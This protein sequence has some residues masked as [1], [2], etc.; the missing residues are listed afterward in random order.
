MRNY[1]YIKCVNTAMNDSMLKHTCQNCQKPM[2]GR[3]D[4]KFCDSQCK[5]EYHNKNR[6]DGE[7]YILSTQRII[8][9]NRRILKMLCPQ[10]KTTVRKSV[11]DQMGFDYR[12]FSGLF[13]SKQT[14]YY[15]VYDYAFAPIMDNGKE[16]ALIVQRQDYMDELGFEVWKK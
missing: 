9:H 13:K 16:K 10:G 5:A 4:K 2:T 1:T 15:L 3:S 7:V 14:L 6:N 12:H 11:L 8:R